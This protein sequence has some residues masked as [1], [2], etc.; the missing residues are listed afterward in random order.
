M[1]HMDQGARAACRKR[2]WSQ[3]VILVRSG[4]YNGA[5]VNALFVWVLESPSGGR[6]AQGGEGVVL[7]RA[8]INAINQSL[9]GV[10][11]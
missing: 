11:R 8:K 3:L 7:R 9:L 5:E 10:P 6:R 2:I 1:A 4:W